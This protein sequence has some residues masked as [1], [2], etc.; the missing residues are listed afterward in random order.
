MML[1]RKQYIERVELIFKYTYFMSL[2]KIV[3]HFRRVLYAKIVL[4]RSPD[5]KSD[6]QRSD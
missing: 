6:R 1:S 5:S 4:L 2:N 3:L